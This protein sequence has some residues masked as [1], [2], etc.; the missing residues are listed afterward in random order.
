MADGNLEDLVERSLGIVT[1]NSTSGTLGLAKGIPVFVMGSA[2]YDLPG[3]THQGVLDDYWRAPQRPVAAIFDAFRRVLIDRCLVVG[4]FA[5][6]SAIHTLIQSTL[7]RLFEVES[8]APQT[9]LEQRLDAQAT[10]AIAA[11][12]AATGS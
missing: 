1:V 10:A 11:A 3:I 9:A 7:T 5:S 6:Q 12:S 2:V 4:G 8:A